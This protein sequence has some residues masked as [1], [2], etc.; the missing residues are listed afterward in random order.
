MNFRKHFSDQLIKSLH[1]DTKAVLNFNTNEKI[2]TIMPACIDEMKNIKIKTPIKY[3]CK[4]YGNDKL[5]TETNYIPNIILTMY[6]EKKIV[7]EF[8]EI[9]NVVIINYDAIIL[10]NVERFIVESK[11]EYD[12]GPI[13]VADLKV[14]T[15]EYSMKKN[16]NTVKSTDDISYY[17]ACCEMSRMAN[18]GIS[19]DKKKCIMFIDKC[20]FCDCDIKPNYRPIWYVNTPKNDFFLCDYCGE[21][22][23][24]K[25]GDSDIFRCYKFQTWRC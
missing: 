8:E 4:I 20:N 24:E 13:S 1:G 5:L 17:R 2:I 10:N 15:K 23:G 16:P 22:I 12:T 11:I 18:S 6:I 14:Y 25:K 19:D 21:I 3:I 9:P 7:L